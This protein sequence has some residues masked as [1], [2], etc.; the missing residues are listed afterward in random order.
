[1]YIKNV[2]EL[3]ALIRVTRRSLGLTQRTLAEA[4]GVSRQWLVE[5]ERGKPRAELEL[6]LQTLR[7]LELM[8][9]VAPHDPPDPPDAAPNEHELGSIPPDIDIDDVIARARGAPR[10]SDAPAAERTQVPPDAPP[11]PDHPDDS[12]GTS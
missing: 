4:V 5:V 10:T 6:V 1:M 7:A 12:E 2:S 8:V 11:Q 3:G 9:W